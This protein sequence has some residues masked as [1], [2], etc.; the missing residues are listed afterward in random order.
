VGK[1]WREGTTV[2]VVVAII[3]WE[4][5]KNLSFTKLFFVLVCKLCICICFTMVPKGLHVDYTS[6]DMNSCHGSLS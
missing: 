5:C 6:S 4:L 3:C 1:K 2:L